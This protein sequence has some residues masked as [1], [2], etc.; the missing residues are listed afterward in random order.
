MGYYDTQTVLMMAAKSHQ[1]ENSLA[2]PPLRG[3][4]LVRSHR[5]SNGETPRLTVE[6]DGAMGTVYDPILVS[7]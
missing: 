6:Q 5:G 7:L 4:G 3:L 2:F 1:A